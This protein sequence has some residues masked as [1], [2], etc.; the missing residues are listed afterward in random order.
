MKM[1]DA[2]QEQAVTV[3]EP[4]DRMFGLDVC[5]TIAILT[6]VIGHMLQHSSPHPLLSSFGFVG[7][8]GVDLFFCLSGFLIGRILLQQSARWPLEKEAGILRF[9]YRRWMRTLPLYF[10]FFIISI[11][12]DWRGSTT[13][14]SQL[15]YLF[16]S[17]NLAWPMTDFFRL[18]WS[19]SVEEWFY[20]SFPLMLL[21]LIGFG[22]NPRSAAAVTVGC[23]LLIPPLMRVALPGHPYNFQN[24]DQGIRQ[25]VMFRMD[26]IGF[27]V[28][29]AFIHQWNKTLF[30]QLSKLWWLFLPLVIVCM[31]CTKRG[32]FGLSEY[33]MVVSLYFSVSAFAFAGLIPFFAGLTPSRFKFLNRFVKYT[34]L[35]SYSMYLGHIFAVM[36]G[37]SI[38]HRFG[39]FGSVY[40]NPWLVYPIFLIFIYLF[41][42]LTYFTIEK[43][44]LAIRDRQS[45]DRLVARSQPLTND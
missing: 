40:P 3:I 43:P 23:Y 19:L 13:V 42:S 44:V 39:V 30:M 25:V 1:T 33:K 2:R 37:I 16:F 29:I 11:K 12:Y 38:F 4:N 24:I 15:S 5:R 45:K 22:K 8:F 26:S 7:L 41:S 21:C 36:I 17:Q 10:F 32:Y 14:S 34:S 28:L 9:W 35:V 31:I 20:F 18:S 6:V 27:G